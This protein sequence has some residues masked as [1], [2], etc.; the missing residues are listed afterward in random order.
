MTPLTERQR[1]YIEYMLT[2]AYTDEKDQ[3]A[4]KEI[5]SESGK[6]SFTELTKLE[7]SRL[8]TSLIERDVE[9]TFVCGE[10]KTLERW[11]AHSF[12]I[13]GESKACMNH[14]PRDL[15]L[16]ECEYFLKYEEEINKEDEEPD[17]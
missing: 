7:A 3:Q 17:D 2:N 14:C 9:Y 6:T 1:E 8:I 5:L 11:I 12:D 10:K 15:Y 16:G 4:L 13:F